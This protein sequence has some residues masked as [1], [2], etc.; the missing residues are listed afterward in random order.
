M[1]AKNSLLPAGNYFLIKFYVK[2]GLGANFIA[3]YQV[4]C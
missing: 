3:N 1:P 2:Y 4:N